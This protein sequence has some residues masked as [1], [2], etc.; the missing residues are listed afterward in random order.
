MDKIEENKIQNP[1]RK[2]QYSKFDSEMQTYKTFLRDIEKS[3]F[4]NAYTRYITEYKLLK[5]I[6]ETADKE[7]KKAEAEELT[8]RL[9][10]V[11][12]ILKEQ[13]GI[14]LH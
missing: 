2:Y 13:N 3:D 5:L 8:N 4:K 7:G 6:I 14:T 10:Q 11:R 12:K 1:N 9:E